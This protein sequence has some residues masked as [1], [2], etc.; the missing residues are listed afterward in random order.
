[1]P[2]ETAD[3]RSCVVCRREVTSGNV[4]ALCM[5]SLDRARAKSGDIYTVIEWAAR[6]ARRFAP[7][8]IKR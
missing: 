8:R 4:C 2:D 3:I 7:K 6:R 5:S 1:M